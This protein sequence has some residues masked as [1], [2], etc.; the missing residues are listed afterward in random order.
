VVSLTQL[1]CKK[2]FISLDVF[3]VVGVKMVP[4]FVT[5]LH[6]VS[7]ISSKRSK[8]VPKYDRHLDEL[9]GRIHIIC[10]IFREPPRA[11]ND[12]RVHKNWES[13]FA[14]GGRHVN[15]ILG[16]NRYIQLAKTIQGIVRLITSCAID[17][18]IVLIL[19]LFDCQLRTE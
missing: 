3:V 2:L 8:K 11:L 4:S 14:T 18:T 9:A 6:I 7:S 16:N 17:E 5:L 12:I 19:R 10:I 13:T 1:F 15:V